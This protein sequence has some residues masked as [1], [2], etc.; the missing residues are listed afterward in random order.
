MNLKKAKQQRREAANTRMALCM[1]MAEYWFQ[2]EHPHWN[3]GGEDAMTEDQAVQHIKERFLR[4]EGFDA[5][6][7]E[8][9]R[10][11]TVKDIAL[12]EKRSK[13]T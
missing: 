13:T 2:R 12:R 3:E 5:V 10:V 6:Q 9:L 11:A 1:D 4:I 8:Q 7:F